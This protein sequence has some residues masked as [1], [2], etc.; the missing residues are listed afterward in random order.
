MKKGFTLIELM[1]VIGIVILITIG[2]IAGIAASRNRRQ[3]KTTAEK[4][5]YVIAE[6]ISEARSPNDSVFGLEKIEVYI[7]PYNSI[8]T[9]MQNQI[10]VYNCFNSACTS[11]VEDTK[12]SFK[13]SKGTYIDA[14]NQPSGG[15]M[16]KNG[17][18]YY[19]RISAKGS[20]IGQIVDCQTCQ[21]SPPTFDSVFLKVMASDG[22]GD[23]YDVKTYIN[24]GLVVIVKE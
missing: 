17:T 12:L 15:N 19:F 4:L 22:G 10:K 21:A 14:T 5:K 9:A 11:K 23:I 1:V 13:A 16:N 18:D 20:S 2:S 6:A 7:Y 24:S 3:V 8:T